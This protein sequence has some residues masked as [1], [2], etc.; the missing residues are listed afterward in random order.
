[1]G[2]KWSTERKD[3]GGWVVVE[4]EK[5]TEE[6]VAEEFVDYQL[7]VEGMVSDDEKVLREIRREKLPYLML[8]P[9]LFQR[10]RVL[11]LERLGCKL[12]RHLFVYGDVLLEFPL[13]V[14]PSVNEYL[15]ALS[16]QRQKAVSLMNVELVILIRENERRR[17]LPLIINGVPV[18][19]PP[20]PPPVNERLLQLHKQAQ[21]LLGML[22][23]GLFATCTFGISNRRILVARRCC[24]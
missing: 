8:P 6:F 9:P 22:Y 23:F 18:S 1:M 2:N 7:E 19:A 10:K 11:G 17:L 20:L 13:L 14:A 5:K 16:K 15:L 21:K 4:I 24:K 12:E 3:L